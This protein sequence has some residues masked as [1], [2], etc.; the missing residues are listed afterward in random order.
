MRS[1]GFAQRRPGSTKLLSGGVDAAQPLDQDEG[2]FGLA[3]ISQE[4][5]GLPAQRVRIV[6]A[7][8]SASH[9]AMSGVVG[10]DVEQYTATV[11]MRLWR[12]PNPVG[13]DGNQCSS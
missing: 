5:A 12:P 2:A 4:P 13:V 7:P 6:S 10:A 9:A 3:P 8:F 11:W 1:E